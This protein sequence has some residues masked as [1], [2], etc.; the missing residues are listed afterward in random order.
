MFKKIKESIFVVLINLADYENYLGGSEK[1][2]ELTDIV[3][4]IQYLISIIYWKI[5][6]LSVTRIVCNAYK[7]THNYEVRLRAQRTHTHW[8]L[9]QISEEIWGHFYRHG[10]SAVSPGLR[11]TRYSVAKSAAAA[12]EVRLALRI[13]GQANCDSLYVKINTK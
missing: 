13:A 6:T 4:L 3:I 10:F 12:P 8:V 9:S 11:R 7:Y 1:V 5:C 2:T